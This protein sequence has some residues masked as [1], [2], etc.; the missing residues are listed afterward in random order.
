M[1]INEIAQMAGVSRATVSRYLNDGYVSEEKRSRIAAV[2]EETGYK[3]SVSAQLLR[4]HH[5]HFIGV[6]IPKLNSDSI[7]RMADGISR[8]LAKEGYQLLLACTENNEQKELGYLSLFRENNVDGVILFGTIFTPEHRRL[9]RELDVPVVILAQHEKGFSCIYSDDYTAAHDMGM[10]LAETAHEA[11]MISVTP[12][13]DA[14][15][16]NRRDGF[17]DAFHDRGISIRRDHIRISRFDAASGEKAALALLQ[18]YPTIDT[19]ICVTDTIASGAYRAIRTM[20]LRIPD[21]IQVSGFGDSTVSTVLYP[22]LT[23]VHLHYDKAG[24]AAAL[25]LLSQIRSG[26]SP[27][28]EIKYSYDLCIRE[29]TRQKDQTA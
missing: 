22:T 13:D 14:V 26:D 9:L 29:S 20:G 16:K 17:I 27:V 2:I 19:L 6:I 5:T 18:K 12:S 11:G 1:T 15:G 21:D 28:N 25:T 7:S 3:P 8:T 10:Y 23:T 24:E 4:S